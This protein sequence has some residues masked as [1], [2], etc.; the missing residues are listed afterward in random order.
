M[1]KFIL[2]MSVPAMFLLVSCDKEQVIQNDDLPAKATS[3]INTH[4][5]DQAIRQ[6]VKERD[7]L[8]TAY[9]VYLDNNTQLDFNREGEIKEIEGTEKIPD[10]ILPALIVTYVNTNYPTA[11]IRA[12]DPN[13]TSQDVKLSTGVELLFDSNGNFL[14][15]EN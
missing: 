2:A 10:A 14:R 11:F 15:I 8:K 1:K 9:H 6:V 3:F 4:Y 13:D 7:D 5:S 12:W